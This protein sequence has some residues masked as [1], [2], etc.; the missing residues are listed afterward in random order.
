MASRKNSGHFQASEFHGFYDQLNP[1]LLVSLNLFREW[2][3]APVHISPLADGVGRYLG[4][5][6]DSQH[7][8]DKW[9]QVNA[10]DFF[11][12]GLKTESDIKRAYDLAKKAGF[13]GIGLYT[14]TTRNGK[15]AIMMHGDVRADK[16]AINPATWARVNGVYVG[17]RQLVAV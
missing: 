14:D 6:K 13:S 15:K 2:W 16:S 1:D 8:I 11:P 7:N 12:E 5:D 10:V 17:I 9:G 4:A 3:G